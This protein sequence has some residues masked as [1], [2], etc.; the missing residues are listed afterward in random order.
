MDEAVEN[1]EE[2]ILVTTEDVEASELMDRFLRG[3]IYEYPIYP[4]VALLRCWEC[5]LASRLSL[6]APL[7]DLGGRPS[8]M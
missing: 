3:L 4:S 2:R 8:R 7:I 1:A 6:V 5:A